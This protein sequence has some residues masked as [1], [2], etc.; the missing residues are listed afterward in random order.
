MGSWAGTERST[1]AGPA[2]L[3]GPSSAGPKK[4][5]ALSPSEAPVARRQQLRIESTN[6]TALL[7][8]SATATATARGR[9]DEAEAAR[10]PPGRPDPVR[11]PQGTLSDTISRFTSRTRREMRRRIY[12]NFYRRR[13]W[14]RVQVELEQY[15]TGPHIAS[16]MLYTVVPSP[17]S[18]ALLLYA[19]CLWMRFRSLL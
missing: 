13:R 16:R 4:K 12:M 15:A 2:R 3:S 6:S 14:W 9:G 5:A 18:D 1:W 7:A 10:G 11:R 19:S 17:D 8:C